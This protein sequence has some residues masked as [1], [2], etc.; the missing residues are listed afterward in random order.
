VL[1]I[2][3]ELGH[4]YHNECQAAKAPLQRRTPMTLAETASIFN[5][6]LVTDAIL[7][8]AADEEEELAVLETFLIGASQ[9]VVDIHSRY[10]FETEV[11]ERRA[12]A[13]LSADD[14]CEIMLRTQRETYGA[15]LDPAYLNPYMW[16]WKPHYY[17][18]KR[19][20]YN[21]PYAFGLL[22]SVGLYSIYREQ[23]EAFA[24]R[25]DGLLRSTGEGRASDLAS[26]FGV[27]IRQRAFWEA[28]LKVI[29]TRIERYC[30]LAERGRLSWFASQ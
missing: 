14:F 17:S 12:R 2:A 1:T 10:L 26:R 16:A 6:T 20:F 24:S 29:E 11:F 28:S 25:Y 23:G 15:G 9:V 7:A 8:Q 27:D 30:S 19:S 22:F 18:A 21:F 13:E 5:E 3:H 4:A